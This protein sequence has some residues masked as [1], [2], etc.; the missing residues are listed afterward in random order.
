MSD[1]L[2]GKIGQLKVRPGKAK[3]D[4]FQNACRIMKVPETDTNITEEGI[5]KNRT[6]HVKLF[7]P[8]SGWTWYIQDWDGSDICFGW[9]IGL[10]KEWGSFSLLELANI[11]GF[12]GLGIEVDEFFQPTS[13][14]KVIDL[15][16][17]ADV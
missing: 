6:F 12:L 8:C 10:D 9:V 3:Y 14:E 15:I 11:K 7:D 1:N 5:T 4:L 16:N 2:Y 17:T 13:T